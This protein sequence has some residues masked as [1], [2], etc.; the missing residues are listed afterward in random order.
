MFLEK[1]KHL[2]PV[3]QFLVIWFR[4]G[5]QREDDLAWTIFGSR[6]A[7]WLCHQCRLLELVLD[8]SH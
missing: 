2:S 8:V 4:L 5:L 7:E 6:R 3:E 1:T